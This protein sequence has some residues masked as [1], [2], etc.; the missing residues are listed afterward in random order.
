MEF[1]IRTLCRIAQ[2]KKKKNNLKNINIT[3][4]KRTDEC[5]TTAR[6]RWEKKRRFYRATSVLIIFSN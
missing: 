1:G 5:T 6:G 2:K 4:P 3:L